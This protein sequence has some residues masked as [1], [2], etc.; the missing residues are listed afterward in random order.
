MSSLADSLVIDDEAL[1]RGRKRRRTSDFIGLVTQKI[2]KNPSTGSST[3]RGRA[4][5]RS[6]SG[7]GSKSDDGRSAASRSKSATERERKDS[8]KYLKVIYT[9]RKRSQS[10][11]RSRSRENDQTPPRRRQRTK[12]RSR[13]HNG[14]EE[15][16][17]YPLAR[18]EI[19]SAKGSE[20]KTKPTAYEMLDVVGNQGG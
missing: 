17:R 2:K 18:H 13:S 12:S 9:L 8:R 1:Q 15:K 20:M 10:P 14:L 4:R 3:L 5:Q 11:S 19:G 16:S 7:C 6:V